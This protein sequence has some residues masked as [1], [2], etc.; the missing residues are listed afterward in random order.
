MEV[1]CPPP[2]PEEEANQV[3]L[4]DSTLNK[5]HLQQKKINDILGNLEPESSE[6]IIVPLEIGEEEGT[7]AGVAKEVLEDWG[8]EAKVYKAF[9][10][11]NENEEVL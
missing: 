2:K 6:L 7:M 11:S 10:A 8:L 9:E 3:M 4:E 5:I 1:L